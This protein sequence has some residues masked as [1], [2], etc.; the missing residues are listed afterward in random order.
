MLGT[1]VVLYLFLGGCGA[2]A[3]FVTAVWSLLFHRTETRTFQQSRAFWDLAGK[4]YLASFGLLA[5]SAFCLLLDLGSPHRF[6][7]LFLRP[8]ASLLSA[9]SFVLLAALLASGCLAAVHALGWPAPSWARKGLEALCAVL[10]TVLMVVPGV[11]G[12]RAPLEQWGAP[13]FVRALVALFGNG[14]SASRGAFCARL[15]T[16]V[17]LD[18]RLAPGA[19]GG[20]GTRVSGACRLSRPGRDK[21]IRRSGPRAAC[22]ARWPS[23]LVLRG[24]RTGRHHRSL[25]R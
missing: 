23:P 6:F 22:F 7:L 9:G 20:P 16:F 17:R 25:R 21:P 19:S 3:L 18:R 4:L 15:G 5:L 2:A 12:S 10:A 1:F 8:T 13:G 24:V 11:D 14:C